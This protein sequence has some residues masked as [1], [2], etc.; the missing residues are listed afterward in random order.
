M[1]S[2]QLICEV[3]GMVEEGTLSFQEA[4]PEQLC[5]ASVAYHNLAVSQLKLRAPDLACRASV[6]A[7][8]IARLCLSFSNRWIDA[9]QYTHDACTEDMKYEFKM[10]LKEGL[11][12]ERQLESIKDLIDA[13]FDP[14]P[15]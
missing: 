7:R 5:I 13:M 3:I 14:N 15:L 6:N 12:D 1:F 4:S 8:K 9:Y 10:K 2:N 11:I